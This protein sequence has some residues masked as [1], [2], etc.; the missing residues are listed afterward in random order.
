MG[1]FDSCCVFFEDKFY[2][3]CNIERRNE[4]DEVQLI[5]KLQEF[6]KVEDEIISSIKEN[7]NVLNKLII[8]IYPPGFYIVDLTKA[9]NNPFMANNQMPYAFWHYV[10]SKK[11][12]FFYHNGKTFSINSDNCDIHFGF[13]PNMNKIFNADN[14]I[15]IEYI[16]FVV[17]LKEQLINCINNKIK[18]LKNTPDMLN[19]FLN[20]IKTNIIQN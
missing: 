2:V 16:R 12:V 19:K 4:M 18:S 5:Q 3:S 14:M 9:N 15:I 1:H 8:S 13:P 17:S 11:I 10:E 20:D 7:I 6:E